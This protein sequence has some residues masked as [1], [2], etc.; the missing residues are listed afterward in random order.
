MN[1]FDGDAGAAMLDRELIEAIREAYREKLLLN[2]P[3]PSFNR[4]VKGDKAVSFAR[5]AA[6]KDITR[7]L[8]VLDEMGLTIIRKEQG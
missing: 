8:A 3:T 1:L 2:P 6:A 4:D 5:F 7:F